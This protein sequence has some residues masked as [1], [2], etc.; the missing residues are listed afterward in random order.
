MKRL[1]IVTL[2]LVLAMMVVACGPKAT[3]EPTPVP[4]APTEAPKAAAPP[5]RPR[6]RQHPLRRL[7]VPRVMPALVRVKRE[8]GVR[9]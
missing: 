5:K 3:P 7:P 8:R 4:A 1:T 6:P 9:D 2:L